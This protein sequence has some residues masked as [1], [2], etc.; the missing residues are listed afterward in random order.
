MDNP[1]ERLVKFKGFDGKDLKIIIEYAYGHDH[2]QIFD[3]NKSL[4]VFHMMKDEF[5]FFSHDSE[6][7]CK[8]MDERLNLENIKSNDAFRRLLAFALNISPSELDD[9][10]SNAIIAM[11]IKSLEDHVY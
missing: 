8:N 1:P 2:L 3:D 10:I 6:I 4:G 5:H 9:A 7:K 11:E